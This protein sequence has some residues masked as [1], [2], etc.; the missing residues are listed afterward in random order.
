MKTKGL[1]YFLCSLFCLYNSFAF[2]QELVYKEI[3][4]YEDPSCFIG[5][6][7]ACVTIIAD[8]SLNLGFR[9]NLDR[10]ILNS[11]ET[12]GQQIHYYL[13]FKP[14]LEFKARVLE[15][16]A[17]TNPQALKI[18]L[19]DLQPKEAQTYLVTVISCFDAHFQEGNKLYVAGQY[20]SAKAKYEEAQRCFDKSL[21]GELEK[22]IVQIDSILVWLDVANESF[23]LLDYAKA[24]RF[25]DKVHTI[26]PADETTNAKRKQALEKREYYC[27]QYFKK[28]KYYL[29][30]LEYDKA[31]QMLRKNVLSG[32]VNREISAAYIDTVNFIIQ[33]KKDRT[34]A[35]TYQLGINQFENPDF[36]LPLSFSVGSYK[37][38]KGGGYFTFFSNP[39]F[40]NMLRKEYAKAVQGNI[41]F[42]TGGTFRPEK[43]YVPLWI[44]IGAGYSLSNAY[45]Y[46]SENSEN[47]IYYGGNSLETEMKKVFYHAVPLEAGIL[48]KI[49]WFVVRYTFQ[50]RFAITNDNKIKDYVS[51]YIHSFGI[52]VC[53]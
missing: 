7:D 4:K 51:P 31:E 17:L 3:T 46:A 16:F 20:Q 47:E 52:G 44:H 13:H 2:S 30:E 36:V 34:T 41:G 12:L 38:K 26:N 29:D 22:K 45:T 27:E 21:D 24:S 18:P 50:Y 43:R 40:F 9:S 6:T 37:T 5:K 53:W 14:G 33:K 19:P 25:Y 15:V 32:C 42:T 8:K 10:D 28:A 11:Q 39:A 23:E 48:L 35:F 1:F 49:N